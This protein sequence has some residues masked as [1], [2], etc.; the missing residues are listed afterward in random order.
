MQFLRAKASD[1]NIDGARVAAWGGSAGAQIAMHLAFND[2]RAEPESDD[3]I[4]RQSTRLIGVATRNGQSWHRSRFGLSRI[5]V[6]VQFSR[7]VSKRDA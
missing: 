7:A 3:P 5:A 1:W 4:E 2:E 6:K